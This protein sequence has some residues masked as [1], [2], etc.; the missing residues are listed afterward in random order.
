MR[1]WAAGM[2]DR[3]GG[4]MTWWAA[5]MTDGGGV[6]TWWTAG[7]TDR[8]RGDDVVDCWNDG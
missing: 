7:M 3:G 1:W 5:G 8:G 2:T 6:M 4:V